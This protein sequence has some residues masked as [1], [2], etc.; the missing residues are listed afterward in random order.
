MPVYRKCD[1]HQVDV[2]GIRKVC[3]LVA[4]HDGNGGGVRGVRR[5]DSC[6]EV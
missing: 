4:R 1:S 5:C 2:K 6:Q 3:Q